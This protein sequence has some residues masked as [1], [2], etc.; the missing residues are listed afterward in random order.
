[1]NN[2]GIRVLV[3]GGTGFIAQHCILTLLSHGYSVR[4]TVRSLTRE[5]EVREHLRTGCA[6]PADHRLSFATANLSSDEGWTEAAAGCAYVM[7]GASPTP[8]GQQKS[9]EDWIRPAVDGKIGRA[10]CRERVSQYV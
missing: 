6:D 3:T 7:H 8:T 9:E 5:A 2:K 10:S 1:M 4:T